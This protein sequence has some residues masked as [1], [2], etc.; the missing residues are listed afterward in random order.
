MITLNKGA[1]H[2]EIRKRQ[3]LKKKKI[4]FQTQNAYTKIQNM[5][6]TAKYFYEFRS[7]PEDIRMPQS[8]VLK[9]TR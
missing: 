2:I 3:E 8:N 4:D 5:Y 6:A 9:K 1:A 7:K